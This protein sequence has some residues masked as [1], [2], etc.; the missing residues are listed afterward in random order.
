MK[1]SA[2]AFLELQRLEREG[3]FV[4]IVP[5][6]GG[7]VGVLAVQGDVEV[8]R[9]GPT[10]AAIAAAVVNECRRWRPFAVAA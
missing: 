5:A 7:E 6:L 1:S 4:A 2:R 9:Q 10:V 3:W 8:H